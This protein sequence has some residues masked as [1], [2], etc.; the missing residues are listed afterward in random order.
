M[1]LRLPRYIG[2]YR[3]CYAQGVLTDE[4]LE[5][6]RRDKEYRGLR[7]NLLGMIKEDYE[8]FCSETNAKDGKADT[9]KI[10]RA[11][12]DARKKALKERELVMIAKRLPVPPEDVPAN[13][14]KREKPLKRR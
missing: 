11:L 4:F 9:R 13:E 5:H 12:I 10:W 2:V 7:G 1:P 14:K 8:T 6:V 3:K